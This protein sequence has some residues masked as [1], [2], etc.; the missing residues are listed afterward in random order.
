MTVVGADPQ[1]AAR[2]RELDK[3]YVLHSWSVQSQVNP[4]PVAGGEGAYFRDPD[5]NR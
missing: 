2:I 4:L 5:G 3:R 1:A